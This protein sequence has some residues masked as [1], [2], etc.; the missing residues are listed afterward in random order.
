LALALQAAGLDAVE[1]AVDVELQKYRRV[2]TRSSRDRRVNALSEAFV[3][4]SNIAILIRNEIARAHAHASIHYSDPA[5]MLARANSDSIE[6]EPFMPTCITGPA[7]TGKTRWR[8]ALARALGEIGKV[9]L[10]PGHGIVPLVPF[11]SVLVGT[12]RSVSQI[13]RPLA[14]PEIQSGKVR[15]SEAD[16]PGECA[17]WQ[18]IV[19]G[20]LFGV[21][22]LQ[23]LTP[24]K[25]D[26]TLV[27]VVLQALALSN[28]E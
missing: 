10:G 9:Q 1:V 16:L 26:S 22:E 6:I 4:T 25:D 19:G 15:I 3:P 17:L 24:S 14:R 5:I 13:L 7:G 2:V 18:A 12:Q 28:V 20:G 11:T 27:T 23:F 8:R 21:D